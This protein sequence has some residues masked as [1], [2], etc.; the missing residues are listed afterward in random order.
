[1]YNVVN[2]LESIPFVSSLVSLEHVHLL[3]LTD[4]HIV[5]S[6]HTSRNES[7]LLRAKVIIGQL[8][9]KMRVL[10]AHLVLLY[11]LRLRHLRQGL[12]S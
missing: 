9:L 5:I 2:I 1:M 11:H 10:K 8:R 4:S 3:K 12:R 7:S 6:Y